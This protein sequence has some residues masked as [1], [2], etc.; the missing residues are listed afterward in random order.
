[1]FAEERNFLDIIKE[2]IIEAEITEDGEIFNENDLTILRGG[3][4]K[5][6]LN[7][8]INKKII[9][10]TFSFGT[11]G[12]NV[13]TATSIIMVTPRKTKLRQ[14]L[15]RITRSGSDLSI[16]RNVIRVLSGML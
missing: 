12:L 10:T 8:A 6:V 2:K 11:E 4:K 15:G 13:A 9:L 5:D 7:D 14:I 1:M 16:I 3:V